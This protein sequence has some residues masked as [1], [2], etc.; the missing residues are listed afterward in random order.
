[1]L[2]KIIHA[3]IAH[4]MN[5]RHEQASFGPLRSCVDHINTLA[6]D[7]GTVGGMGI[8]PIPDLH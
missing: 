1:M 8:K 3:R 5:M 2:A 4:T 6:H 7:L